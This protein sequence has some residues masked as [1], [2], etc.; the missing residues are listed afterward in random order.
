MSTDFLGKKNRLPYPRRVSA[1]FSTEDRPATSLEEAYA[2]R[3]EL[4]NIQRSLSNGEQEKVE[5]MKSL[6][7]LKDDLTRLQHSET[8]LDDSSLNNPMEK[9]SIASQTDLS[10]DVRTVGVFFSS[11]VM[12]QSLFLQ[13][14]P[15]GA[16]LNEM[17]QLRLQYDEA[18]RN[19]QDIQQVCW[20]HH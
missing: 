10:G 19:V 12:F 8:A 2:I 3:N 18:R 7:C 15:I 5:L 17:T 9:F 20:W 1:K 14:I 13:L 4:S 16:R 6:A 11:Q